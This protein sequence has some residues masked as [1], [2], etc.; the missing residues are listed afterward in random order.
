M[1]WLVRGDCTV[2]RERLDTK[3]D[4]L[5]STEDTLEFVSELSVQG[6]LDELAQFG[7]AFLNFSDV[8]LRVL[9]EGKTKVS[10][11][12]AALIVKALEGLEK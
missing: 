3:G 8:A 7:D 1:V 12:A 6:L 2:K 9:A 4:S 5:L 11:G 10:K